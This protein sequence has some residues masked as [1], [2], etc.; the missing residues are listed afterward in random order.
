MKLK[1]IELSGFKSFPD[2]TRIA[3]DRGVTAI[4]GPNGSG[5]SNISDAVRWVLGEMSP[6]SLR[7]SKMEDVI[8]NGTSGR[9]A[10]NCAS[11]SLILDTSAEYAAAMQEMSPAAEEAEEPAEGMPKVPRPQR[12]GDTDEVVVTRK[13]YRSGESEYYINKRQ[14]RLKDVYEM[15]YDTGIG[16]EGYSVIGQGRIAEVL[17]QKGDE[18]R[19]IFEEASGISK[20]RYKKLEAERKLRDT[21]QN[22]VRI[23]DI[24]SE[25][26]S[27]VE[28]LRKEAENAKKYLVLNEEK[29][30]L[31]ITLWLN[32]IDALKT[33]REK[34]ENSRICAKLELDA[35]DSELSSA[36]SALDTLINE[37]YEKARLSSETERKIT[38]LERMINDCE[39]RS[40]VLEN[41]IEHY[42]SVSEGAKAR[43]SDSRAALSESER[44]VN[45]ARECAQRLAAQAAEKLELVREAERLC[46][47]KASGLAEIKRLRGESETRRESLRA[48]R[49]ALSE[50]RAVKNSELE[51]ALAGTGEND[52]R[53]AEAAQRMKELA[54]LLEGH[55][56]ELDTADERL[57]ALSAE[58]EEIKNQILAA[59]ERI[60]SLGDKAV[61]SRMTVTGYEQRREA[62]L[63]MERLLEG[64]SDGVRRVLTDANGGRLKIKCYG[65]VSQIITAHEGYA[66]ALETALAAAVQFIVVGTEAD[67]KAAIEHLKANRAGRATFLPV[68][69]ISG[70]TAD[71]SRIS[72]VA[73]FVG[74]ASSLADYDA[75]FDGIVRDLLGRT[76]VAENMEAALEIA[77]RT[78]FRLKI[79]TPDG[80]IINSGGSMT[81]GSA[82]KRVGIF[83]RNADIE[84]LGAQIKKENAALLELE[85]EKK[86]LSDKKEALS[87]RL[88]GNEAEYASLRN[89]RETAR[90]SLGAAEAL[91]DE[92]KRKRDELELEKS[93]RGKSI[94]DMKAQL[95]D[96]DKRI[97]ELDSELEDCESLLGTQ[98]AAAASFEAEDRA[99]V[100]ALAAARLEYSSAQTE[101]GFKNELLS[102]AEN[103]K[104]ALETGIAESE[105]SLSDMSE[106]VE[107]ATA[108]LE[109]LRAEA[110]RIRADAD[111]LREET[112]RISAERDK[113][114]QKTAQLRTHI[115]DLQIKKDEAF[116][117]HTALS[118]KL[119]LQNGEYESVTNKLWDEYEMTY[120]AACEHRLPVEKMDKAPSRLAS[121]K[122][123]IRAMGSINA[124]AVEE[125]RETKERF[126]FLTAQ[127]ED[128]NKT[129]RSLDNAISR[130]NG[131]MKSTF[132][133]CFENINKT[134]GEVFT[135]L[136]GGGSARLELENPDEPL[137]CGIDIIIR[138]PGK[139][140][141]SISLL[142]GGEQSFAAIALYLALQKINPAPFCIFDEIES[143]LDDVNLA[144]FAEYV[145]D[146]SDSTQYILITHRRGTMERAD[147][148][149]GITMHEKGISDYIRLNVTE[150][151]EKIK[152]YTR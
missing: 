54:E 36:E 89:E 32:R 22:L 25:V 120:T 130:L 110:V 118:N 142:S 44:R 152:E 67:A 30:A 49:A 88:S 103:E 139:T 135:E 81:G 16:R 80:Q 121:L 76:V 46:A 146:H 31:E 7:G 24:L 93:G 51:A 68:S 84:A 58:S 98:T 3:F 123:Q 119:E 53:L 148:L 143:A 2:K 42:G 111:T 147:T 9:N 131:S 1:S 33:E 102:A 82:A 94:A 124:N 13:Y 65:T 101:L 128:L 62:L 14:V 47:E 15:F 144:R 100:E 59:E 140:V 107:K 34:T 138:P 63:R 38:E 117:S 12:I 79:V 150:L 17:S 129:R 109:H 96:T 95:E 125:Y 141:K 60:A 97:S 72:D 70:R 99:A 6:K 75:K 4:I 83:S 104:K 28:P 105:K 23:N 126:D 132:A 115:K 41:D 137:D 45:E 37:S 11:V 106:A 136:F 78:Q 151:G 145:R 8:F 5:K 74:I 122:S 35:A 92:A 113:N 61:E 55:R 64:Y 48:E 71:M 86:R 116:R 87:E 66:L 27:R 114:E 18:R 57:E 52:R 39:S 56:K 133:E 77:R 69:V 149:Y 73:G 21:E 29:T 91:Y 112:G 127:T 50:K 26:S 108:E 40:A 90:A 85:S 10:A 43:M 134:F 19:S 20:F